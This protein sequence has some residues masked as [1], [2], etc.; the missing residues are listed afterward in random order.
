MY[1]VGFRCIGEGGGRGQ[2]VA[3]G[4]FHGHVLGSEL[5]DFWR[6]RACF[7]M[8]EERLF[9]LLIGFNVL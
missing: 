8:P 6:Y 7:P 1:N 3:W 4:E 2:E 9:C 5:G